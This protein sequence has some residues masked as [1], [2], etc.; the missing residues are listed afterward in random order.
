MSAR[1]Y[2]LHSGCPQLSFLSLV[3]ADCSCG[4]HVMA[5]STTG[6]VSIK[7]YCTHPE[8]SINHAIAPNPHQGAFPHLKVQ[9]PLMGYIPRMRIV[10]LGDYD[11]CDVSIGD[12][13]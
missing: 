8:R 3:V 4:V 9:F 2:A 11:P 10:A 13:A 5:S 6:C 1:G 7:S 12:T